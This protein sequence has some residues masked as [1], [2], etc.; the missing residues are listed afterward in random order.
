MQE[1]QARTVAR[2]YQVRGINATAS[3]SLPR[4]EW[5][6]TL[7]TLGRI[8]ETDADGD[9]A[10][11]HM[12]DVKRWTVVDAAIYLGISEAAAATQLR[13]WRIASVGRQPGRGGRNLYRASD[14][15]AAAQRRPGQ[16]ARTDLPSAR[17]TATH[18]GDTTA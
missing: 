8:I 11:A 15:R 12:L 1:T 5:V 3:F 14:V 18:K 2:I 16:G 10:I 9:R 4:L 13:R 17:R 7:T 6:V